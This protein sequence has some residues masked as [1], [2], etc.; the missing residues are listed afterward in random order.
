M[1][2][3]AICCFQGMTVSQSGKLNLLL[4]NILDDKEKISIDDNIR[5]QPDGIGCH[6]M[7]RY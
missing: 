1:G 3:H 4:N 2:K 6:R 5:D 7:L